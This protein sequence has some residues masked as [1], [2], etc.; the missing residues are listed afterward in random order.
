M[1]R[2]LQELVARLHQTVMAEIAAVF[3][4]H[5]KAGRIAKLLNR[6][7]YKREYHRIAIAREGLHGTLHDSRRV[8]AARRTLIPR[9]QM[10]EGETGILTCA[11]QAEA[12]D[13]EDHIGIG[14]LVD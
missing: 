4:L 14:L 13:D 9:L 3:H 2:Q 10:H 5:V 1:R 8:I 7:R 11:S 12:R 6:G